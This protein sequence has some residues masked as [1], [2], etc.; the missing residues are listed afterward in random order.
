MSGLT[1]RAS[2]D[3]GTSEAT[4]RLTRDEQRARTRAE[5]LAAAGRVF[6]QHGYHATSVDMVAEAAGFTKGAVYSNFE[7]KEDLFLALFEARVEATLG[8]VQRFMDES[9]PEDRAAAFG[10]PDMEMPT[11]EPDWFL[12]EA[13]FELYAARNPDVRE[14]LARRQRQTLQVVESTVRRY[15]EELGLVP[16]YPVE[17]LAQLVVATGDGISLMA[18]NNPDTTDTGRLMQILLEALAKGATLD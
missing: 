12:L 9:A 2:T 17:Q 10:S 6:A 7:S 3:A 15:I 16:A 4:E 18:L 8:S 1:S 13:E 11:W 5:L 14:R